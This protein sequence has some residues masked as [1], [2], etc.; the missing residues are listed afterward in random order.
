MGLPLA[1]SQS[2]ASLGFT[3]PGQLVLRHKRYLGKGQ[4]LE[5]GKPLSG[6]LPEA[7]IPGAVV[8]AVAKSWL[9]PSLD[10]PCPCSVTGG[11]GVDCGVWLQD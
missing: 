11:C 6:L 2:R 10:I 4:D 7:P 1:P 3:I 5:L 9:P 8:W